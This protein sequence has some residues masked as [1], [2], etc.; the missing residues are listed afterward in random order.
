DIISSTTTMTEV[1]MNE[2][3]SAAI[4]FVGRLGTQLFPLFAGKIAELRATDSFRASAFLDLPVNHI[5]T[6]IPGVTDCSP[7]HAERLAA[8][9]HGE[10]EGQAIQSLF[11]GVC[12]R[13]VERFQNSIGFPA[14]L[15]FVIDRRLIVD[16][17]EGLESISRRLSLHP[18]L[19]LTE[20][21]E[22]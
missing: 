20:L 11:S 4:V 21:S 7:S 5:D 10:T 9:A 16:C 19:V 14:P 22:H 12:D 18:L 8:V 15:I 6:S 3:E 13:L 1:T 17:I 2:L